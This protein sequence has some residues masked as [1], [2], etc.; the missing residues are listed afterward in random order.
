MQLLAYQ[1]I[2]N[3][4]A[5][6]LVVEVLDGRPLDAFL[7]VLFLWWEKKRVQEK[8]GRKYIC[9]FEILTDIFR[10][11]TCT[12]TRMTHFT[13]ATYLLSLQSQFNEDLLQFLID[14]V[15]TELLKSISL[16]GHKRF[17]SLSD[18]PHNKS[19]L[20]VQYKWTYGV[21]VDVHICL[22]AGL[23][24]NISNP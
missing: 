23:T 13:V 3:E 11:N 9:E 10:W 8:N 21:L 20:T 2:F 14:K 15:D 22:V 7:D 5:H 18:Y 19:K 16:F 17:E 1:L 6:N 4:V 24:W 12:E